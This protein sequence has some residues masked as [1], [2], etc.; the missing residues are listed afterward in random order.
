M[1]P[2]FAHLK[3]S[4]EKFLTVCGEFPEARWQE[5]PAPN[6][7]SAAEVAAHVATIEESIIFGMKRLLRAAPTPLSWRKRLHPPLAIATWR[8]RKVK[9]PIPLDPQRVRNQPESF[10]AL[11]AARAN[12]LQFIE[13]TRGKDVSSY[14]FA[15]PFLG[16]LNMYEWFRTIGYHD[17]RHVKQIRELVEMFHV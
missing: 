10:S 1:A 13:S 11:Q 4:R 5:S 2:I 15:H 6:S 17:L 12:T 7:W 8:V 16:S 14:R 3:S 9:S